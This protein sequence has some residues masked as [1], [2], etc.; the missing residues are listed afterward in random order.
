QAAEILLLERDAIFS[1]QADELDG[2]AGEHVVVALL[3]DHASAP[4]GALHTAHGEILQ[5]KPLL[6]AVLGALPADAG[7]L[8]PAEGRHLRR[9]ETGVD[10]DDSVL[11]RLRDTPDA[12]HVAAVEVRGETVRC[13]VGDLDRVV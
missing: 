11:K 8:H 5:L 10:P 6:D 13:R 4:A 7:F 2:L 3:D 9:D 12:S 1:V